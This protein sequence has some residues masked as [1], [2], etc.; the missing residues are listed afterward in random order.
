MKLAD[1]DEIWT[2]GENKKKNNLAKNK[3]NNGLSKNNELSIV[4]VC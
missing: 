1:P 3:K 4:D 2:F